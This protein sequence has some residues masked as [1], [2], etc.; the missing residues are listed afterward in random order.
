MERKAFVRGKKRGR[1]KKITALLS[2]FFRSKHK[3]V[4]PNLAG[5]LIRFSALVQSRKK[6]YFVLFL[7]GSSPA[8]SQVSVIVQVRFRVDSGVWRC[9]RAIQA[10]NR[11]DSIIGET[12]WERRMASE[13]CF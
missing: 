5:N 4:Q 1:D 3:N 2:T 7:G 11:K 10:P 6:A 12:M 9:E 13:T 8:G